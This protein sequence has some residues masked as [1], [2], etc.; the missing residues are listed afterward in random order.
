MATKQPSSPLSANRV[1]ENY[2][3]YVYFIN[4]VPEYVGKGCRTRCLS[5]LTTKKHTEWPNHL[6][7]SVREGRKICISIFP[8]LNEH[9][10]YHAQF[11]EIYWIAFYGRRDTKTGTLYNTTDGGEGTSGRTVSDTERE[12]HRIGGRKAWA[13]AT[14]DKRKAWGNKMSIG[15][16]NLSAEEKASIS[17]KRSWQENNRPPEIEALRCS[18][19]AVA[20]RK[21]CTLDFTTIYP[22]VQ[23]LIAEKGQGKNGSRSPN[24]HYL[25]PEEISH[26]IKE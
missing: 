18:K 1:E 6:Q 23:D 25:T 10:S 17:A 2:Y 14:A 16:S 3:T 20:H 11:G 13:D 21:Y 8:H 24:L 12:A 15:W 26:Y 22:S 9:S 5:H 7:K 19:I 4:D